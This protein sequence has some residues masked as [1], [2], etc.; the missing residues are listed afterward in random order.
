MSLS[1]TPLRIS[2]AGMQDD[3]HII[4]IETVDQTPFIDFAARWHVEARRVSPTIL[5]LYFPAHDRDLL[6]R[7]E[8]EFPSTPK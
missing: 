1:K 2:N 5:S 4:T 3:A 6:D 7:F 8:R